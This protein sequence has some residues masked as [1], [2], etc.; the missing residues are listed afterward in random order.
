MYEYAAR[1]KLENEKVAEAAIKTTSEVATEAENGSPSHPIGSTGLTSQSGGPAQNEDATKTA[2]QGAEAIG[3]ASDDSNK[4]LNTGDDEE[5]AKLEVTSQFLTAGLPSKL[6]KES[7]SKFPHPEAEN[8][9][10]Q[11]IHDNKL[12]ESTA[13]SSAS[14]TILPVDLQSEEPGSKAPPTL[15][16][17]ES[18]T[19]EQPLLSL[20]PREVG[21]FSWLMSWAKKLS[22][23][24]LKTGFRRIEWKCVGYPSAFLWVRV[25][26]SIS[27]SVTILRHISSILAPTSTGQAIAPAYL[28]WSKWSDTDSCRTADRICTLI[29]QNARGGSSTSWKSYCRALDQIPSRRPAFNPNLLMPQAMP[30]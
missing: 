25:C 20:K 28:S 24:K 14:L 1:Q 17:E 27:V 6:L 15:I 23:P 9:G 12:S 3:E 2:I 30:P 8:H 5:L 22:R 18:Q 13:E 7:P 26:P 21:S 10:T 29:F 11:R 19:A 16:S 4:L